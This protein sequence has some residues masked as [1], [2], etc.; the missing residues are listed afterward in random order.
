[1]KIRGHGSGLAIALSGLAVVLAASGTAYA[2]TATVV[3][4]ADPTTP[5]RV[6][7]VDAAGRL[8]TVEPVVTVNLTSISFPNASH[9]GDLYSAPTSA[10]LGVSKFALVPLGPTSGVWSVYLFQVPVLAD[11]TCSTTTTTRTLGYAV[12]GDAGSAGGQD[13]AVPITVTPVGTAKYC[14]DVFYRLATG[15][16]TGTESFGLQ[17]TAYAISG[18]YSA[19]AAADP[20][21]ATPRSKAAAVAGR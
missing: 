5:S 10:P 2:V 14:L 12:A 8:N 13:Y 20:T 16:A 18:K 11:G 6:A 3:N 21:P 17:V 7:K 15:T 4:I 19:S 1:M 9:N